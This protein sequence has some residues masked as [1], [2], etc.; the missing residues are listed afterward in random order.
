MF[1][2]L[3]NSILYLCAVSSFQGN[4]ENNCLLIFKTKSLTLRIVIW[5]TGWGDLGVI[6]AS[7]VMWEQIKWLWFQIYSLEGEVHDTPL[8]ILISSLALHPGLC[9]FW[10]LCTLTSQLPGKRR[11]MPRKIWLLWEV[12][13]ITKGG[14]RQDFERSHKRYCLTHICTHLEWVGGWQIVLHITPDVRMRRCP[15]AK[16]KAMKRENRWN[17]FYLTLSKANEEIINFWRK[18]FSLESLRKGQKELGI[19][20]GGSFPLSETF[21]FLYF[22]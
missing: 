18:L 1:P 3:K 14:G 5:D 19:S 2:E 21:F 9:L 7:V 4:M 10:F 16:G 15:G 13:N 22:S 6:L 8:Y 17:S 11:V 12:P 20:Y